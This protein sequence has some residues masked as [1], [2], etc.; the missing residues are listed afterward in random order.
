MTRSEEERFASWPELALVALTCA[1]ALQ[2]G[3]LFSDGS[4]LGPVLLAGLVA[5]LLAWGCRRLGFG[6][7]VAAAVSGIGLVLLISWLFAAGSTLAGIPRAATWHVIA[8]DLRAS[9]QQFGKLIAPV[10]PKRG[11]VI[12]AMTGVWCAA[13]LADWAAF[14]LSSALEAIVPAFGLFVFASA[15]GPNKHRL[16]ATGLMLGAILLFL[17]MHDAA[18]RADASAWF[19]TRVRGGPRAIVRGGTVIGAIALVTA[20]LVGPLL[21]GA[22]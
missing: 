16:A 12:A 15:L 8:D 1:T 3:R 20:L 9:W 7:V 21:P 4:Y 11:F 13:F 10:P 18:R 17:L 6:L 14:R 5:H 19:A 2:I 22:Q